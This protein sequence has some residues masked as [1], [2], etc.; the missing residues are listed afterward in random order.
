MSTTPP[1]T[2]PAD[3]YGMK[4]SH[5]VLMSRMALELAG[6]PFKSHDILPGLHGVVVKLRRFPASTV[7]ALV[8]DGR[9]V[10]GTKAIVREVHRLAPDAGLFPADPAERA[11]VEEAEAFGHD[12]LQTVARRVFRWAGEHDNAVRAWMAKEVVGVP[13]P[14]LMGYALKPVMIYFGR[15]VVHATND[16]IRRDLASLPQLMD[17]VDELLDQRTIGGSRPNAADLQIFCSL[18]LLIAHDDL[19]PLITPRPCG[20]ATLRLLPDYP[21]SGT[22]ALPPVPAVLPAEWLPAPPAAAPAAAV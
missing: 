1:F 12:E 13:A 4:H 10:Q 11:A 2:R 8:I 16:Q 7:P 17:H 18:R 15:I 20:Q 14:T 6:L 3:L 5:P 19:R 9:K 21:R 22:D